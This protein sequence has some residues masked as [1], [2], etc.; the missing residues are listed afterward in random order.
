MD[1]EWNRRIMTHIPMFEDIKAKTML[2]EHSFEAVEI[3]CVL[4]IQLEIATV[5]SHY[6]TIAL[7]GT[8]WYTRG[9]MRGPML[10][11]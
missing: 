7:S 10:S 5:L 4:Y 1:L 3:L 2:S 6:V 9:Y 11:F 8:L